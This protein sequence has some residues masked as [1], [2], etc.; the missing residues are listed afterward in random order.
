MKYCACTLHLSGARHGIGD[1]LQVL[2]DVV[3]FLLAA[4]FY[5]IFQSFAKFNDNQFLSIGSAVDYLN[6]KDFL[7]SDFF[8]NS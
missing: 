5:R 3:P 6:R 4:T 1:N 7:T 8:E 2:A